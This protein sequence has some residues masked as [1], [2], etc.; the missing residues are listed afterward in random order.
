MSK[1]FFLCVSSVR[2]RKKNKIRISV[3]SDTTFVPIKPNNNQKI[4]KA[5]K[6]YSVKK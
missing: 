1:K 5:D 4:E 2:E 3:I 6:S